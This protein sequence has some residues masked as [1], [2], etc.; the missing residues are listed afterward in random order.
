MP[1]KIAKYDFIIVE[2]SI[3]LQAVGQVGVSV[4]SSKKLGQ[5]CFGM[6]AG[7]CFDKWYEMT[8][9]RL[10]E[11]ISEEAY[12]DDGNRD[13]HSVKKMRD[14]KCK[15]SRKLLRARE[16]CPSSLLEHYALKDHSAINYIGHSELSYILLFVVQSEKMLVL[17]TRKGF[18]AYSV[19]YKNRLADLTA[20]TS[21]DYFILRYVEN[22]I[23]KAPLFVDLE[24][25][26]HTFFILGNCDAFKVLEFYRNSFYRVFIYTA[27]R[28][29][30][31]KIFCS[32]RT[33]VAYQDVSMVDFFCREF[34]TNENVHPLVRC[35][36][37]SGYVISAVRVQC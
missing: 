34:Q 9:N 11:F 25:F 5:I 7:L 12:V 19:F 36:T 31:T 33:D 14:R 29:Y 1:K 13:E 6:F 35:N 15:R 26:Y 8:E 18:F 20:I 2:L 16:L 32:L 10:V 21:S 22:N 28:V 4:F 37:G 27:S 30:A 3:N 23:K 24:A 17:D